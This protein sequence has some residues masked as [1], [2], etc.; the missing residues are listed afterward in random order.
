MLLGLLGFALVWL[1]QLA[2]DCLSPPV[3]NIEQ[4]TWVRSLQWGYFKHPPLPTW[5]VWAPTQLFGLTP[6]TTYLLGAA[7]TLGSLFIFWRLLLRLRGLSYATVALLAALCITYYN[8]RLYY[9]NHNIVLMLASTASA[10][11]TWQA[12]TTRRLRWWAALGVMLGLGALSKYQI[13]VTVLSLLAF[14]AHQRAWRDAA[15]RRGLL[16]AGAVSALLFAP[17][18]LWLF[19]H[20]FEP[21]HYAMSSSLGAHIDRFSRVVESLRWLA[22]QLLN[23]AVLAFILLWITA[24]ATRKQ[25][26]HEAAQADAAASTA[27]SRDAARALL[28][29]WGVVPFVF[30]FALGLFTGADLQLQWGTAFLLFAVPAAMELVPGRLWARAN[31]QR[32]LVGFA[33]IQSLLLIQNHLASPHSPVARLRDHHWRSFDSQALADAVAAPAR[34]ALG[35][36]IRVVEGNTGEAGALSLRLPEHPRVLIDGNYA[37]SPWLKPQDVAQCGALVIG[38]PQGLPGEHAVGPGF[39]MRVWRVIPPTQPGCK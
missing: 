10:A 35:G 2:H 6:W 21:L 31:L 37:A 34:A 4:L 11:L 39:P 8:D 29:S 28:L 1:A 23:R 3:D 27:P 14:A 18:F 5:L 26:A 13:A 17:H 19:S 24:R 36:P 15:H 30:T 33:V 9:Y 7:L 20:D 32:V 16:L 12:F 22:D 38:S 25:L